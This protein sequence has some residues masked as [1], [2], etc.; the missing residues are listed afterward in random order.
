MRFRTFRRRFV[1]LGSFC[2]ILSILDSEFYALN[3]MIRILDSLFFS[4][5]LLCIRSTGLNSKHGFG[6][7]V[8]IHLGFLEQDLEFSEMYEALW[9]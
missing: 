6:I 3:F 8:W 4:P 5:R 7:Q 2:K 1:S 9:V